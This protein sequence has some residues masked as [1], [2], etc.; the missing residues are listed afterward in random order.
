MMKKRTHRHIRNVLFGFFFV[1]SVGFLTIA[2][3]MLFWD[4]L[5]HPSPVQGAEAPVLEATPAGANPVDWGISPLAVENIP[6]R[7]KDSKTFDL[8]NGEHA[9]V[10]GQNIHYRTVTGAW[11]DVD[12]NFDAAGRMTKHQYVRLGIN[13]S[14]LDATGPTGK[15]VR[16]YTPVRPT[17][18]RNMASYVEDGRTWTYRTTRTGVKLESVVLVRQGPLTYKFTYMM[19]GGGSA[20]RINAR[21]DAVSEGFVIKRARIIGNN[22]VTYPAE[23]W[24]LL[25]GPALGF[26][27]DDTLLPLA[28]YPYT[29]DP[30]TDFDIAAS[31]N[32]GEALG[33]NA[34]YASVACTSTSTTGASAAIRRSFNGGLHN[35]HTGLY[36]WDTSS[37]PD[38]G[39]VTSATFRGYIADRGDIDN[40]S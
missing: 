30:T 27:F 7:T 29:I 10:F 26:F 34:T 5:P 19:L 9:T 11:D 4:F 12:L 14:G 40:R 38:A 28:A 31:G 18:N 8:P 36:R 13:D 6:E 22:G 20:F 21:G 3:W 16:W 32:D 15:G 39:T 17:P 24:T 1:A 23:T 25:P 2:F 35:I 33:N 37:L